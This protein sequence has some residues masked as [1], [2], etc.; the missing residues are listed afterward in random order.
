MDAMRKVAEEARWH[1]RL[2]W[3]EAEEELGEAGGWLT[4]GGSG[5]G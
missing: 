5:I 3:K 4:V 1:V 2:L